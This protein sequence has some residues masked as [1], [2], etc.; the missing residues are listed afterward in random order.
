M[1]IGANVREK[2]LERKLTQEQLAELVNVR[3]PMICQIER[4]SRTL[5][6]PLGKAIAE[7]LECTLDDLV[8]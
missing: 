1:D 6:L 4:G 2:R 7:V 5:T 8:K 3:P